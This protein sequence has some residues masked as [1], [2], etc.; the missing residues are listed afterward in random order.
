MPILSASVSASP[1]IVGDVQDG[2]VRQFAVQAG[3]LLHHAVAN[4]RVQRRQ[5][6]IQQQYFGAHRDGAGDRHAL[7]LATGELAGIALGVGGHADDGQRLFDALG[8]QAAR[9]ALGAQAERHI[10]LD[11]H[12]RKQRVVLYHHAQ[13][14]LIRWHVGDIDVTDGNTPGGGLHEAG[15]RP[16]H[17]GFTRTGGADQ[18]QHFAGGDGE[19]QGF[20]HLGDAVRH[21]DAVEL[22]ARRPGDVLSCY[23]APRRGKRG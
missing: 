16:Q 2:Q 4:L 21:A 23:P 15:D 18:R 20:Q 12:M 14:A 22:N 3:D 5:R 17:G 6:L 11:A 9:L 13:A 7:L 1:L 19:R 10:V 8:G